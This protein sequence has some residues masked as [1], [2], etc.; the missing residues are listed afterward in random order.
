MEIHI[1]CFCDTDHVVML[2]EI[3]FEPSP[4][5]GGQLWESMEIKANRKETG[6]SMVS[7]NNQ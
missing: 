3:T 4:P 5:L 2:Y 1:T 7:V 6:F